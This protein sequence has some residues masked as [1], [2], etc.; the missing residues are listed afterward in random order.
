MTVLLE[1]ALRK[2]NL[3]IEMKKP[4]LT[5]CFAICGGLGSSL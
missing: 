5:I 4:I 1:Q 2:K 3:K